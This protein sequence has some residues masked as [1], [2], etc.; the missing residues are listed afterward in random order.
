M[1]E[2]DW[3]EILNDLLKVGDLGGAEA[4]AQTVNEPWQRAEALCRVAKVLVKVN[5]HEGARRVWSEAVAVA[6]DGERSINIQDSLDCA[7]VLAELS[8]D[9][10]RAGEVTQAKGV[11]QSIRNEWGRN[12][13]LSIVARVKDELGR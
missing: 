5:D 3:L 11:A 7:S 9:M 4:F 6:Q 10:L 12:R 1:D 13:A 2:T 8:L